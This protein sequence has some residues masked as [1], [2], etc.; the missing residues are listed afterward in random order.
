MPYS[1]EVSRSNPMCIIFLV[2]QSGSMNDPFGKDSGKMK[3][4]GVADAINQL[5]DTLIDSCTKQG[6][7]LDRYHIGVIGYGDNAVS[8]LQSD[9]GE[10]DLVKISELADSPLRTETRSRKVFDGAGGFREHEV[11][12]PVWFEPMASGQTRMREA[13]DLAATFAEEFIVEHPECRPPIVF[14]IT[15]G[16][17]HEPDPTE[18]AAKQLRSIASSDGNLLLFQRSHFPSH[19]LSY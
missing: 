8:L 9:S 3:S 7:V 16:A 14:N 4:E 17:P 12:F 10:S 19:P 1:A 2:D 6:A 5:I 15:D 13:I 18:Q 11:V